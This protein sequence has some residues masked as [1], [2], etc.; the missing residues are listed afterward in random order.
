MK[1]PLLI[2]IGVEELPAIPF[3]K[4]L[5]NIVKKWQMILEENNLLCEFEFF[6]TPRRLIF[7]HKEFPSRQA[8]T[9]IELF[10]APLE[11]SYKDGEPTN[12]ALGFAKKCGVDISQIGRGEKNGKEV[13]YF[14]KENR[15]KNSESLLPVMIE[16]LLEKLS[17]GKSMRWGEQKKS[18]I[19]PIRWIGCMLDNQVIDCTL[20]GV[21]SANKS[22]GHRTLSF[23]PF[24]YA[25]SDDFFLKLEKSGVILC[26]KE[27]EKIILEQFKKIEKSAHCEIEIDKELLAEIVAITENPHALIGSFDEKFLQ[28]P[29]EVIITSMKEHQRYF[30]VFSKGK[31]TNKFIVVSNAITHDY[32]QIIK[33]NEKVLYPRLADGL[34]F[35][36]NDL[37]TRLQ[38]E[39]LKKITF[40]QGA[41]SIYDKT[42]REA[43]IAAILADKYGIQDKALLERSVLLSKAD[44]LSD[45]VYEFTELQGLMGYYYAKAS[46][47]KEDLAIALK[48]Q[49]LPDGEDTALPS[50]DFSAVL[51][52]S[53]KLDSIMTLFALGKIPTG[54]KDPFALRRAAIGVI[55]I[56]LDRGFAFDIRQDLKLL[57]Q[58][59]SP[60]ESKVVEDFFIDR[61]K[62]HFNVNGS[63]I[64]A[65]LQTKE[66]DLV[67]IA[68]KVE[69]LNKIVSKSDF[70]AYTSTFKR[71]ANIIKDVDL[72]TPIMIEESLLA[73]SAEKR[74]YQKY[75][76]IKAQK[77]HNYHERLDTLFALKPEIDDFF[78][79]VMV[80]VEDERI[81]QNR[82]NLITAL[83]LLFREI[84]DI[85][86]ITV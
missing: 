14:Q 73:E 42:L 16:T 79:S 59:Y 67:K 76:Q 21:K 51:A 81:K 69:A 66:R 57:A 26:A 83:Y 4:E 1:K 19:R 49:Y 40:M 24:S 20:Y 61:I 37:K 70:K 71:I 46:G 27:R 68:Q 47:E 25:N 50:S 11:I 15:G 85:K 31:L 12:A 65:V 56:V 7:W 2:E 13:L 78:E 36:E 6:Y 52:M 38:T 62:Q 45:M 17:F 77:V 22:Y 39:G 28:L 18:F 82:K 9:T 64:Q 29:P 58:K 72:D 74:L 48:E 23:E 60:L 54:T 32:S 44:L 86:E 8:D 34:F 63:I 30:A 53:H 10:G 33:G 41:G 35:M 3:L 80:N 55:K 75:V 5:P 43:S 84:A